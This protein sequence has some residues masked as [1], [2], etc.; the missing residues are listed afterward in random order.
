MKFLVYGARGW[1]GGQFLDVL[2]DASVEHAEATS[3]ADDSHGILDDLALHQP[4]HVVSFIGRTHGH[5][6]DKVF[7][8]IDYLEQDGKLVEN[9]R[10]NLFSPLLLATTCKAHNIHF[11][12]LGTGCIFNFDAALGQD[13]GFDEDSLPNFFGSSYSV[14]KGFPHSHAHYRGTPCPQFHH[15]NHHLRPSLLRAQFHDRAP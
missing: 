11:T 8:T 7:T 6:G 10:D 2:R 1:I 3:R 13:G 12:Y 4:T 9:M 14:V 5:I 15:Q